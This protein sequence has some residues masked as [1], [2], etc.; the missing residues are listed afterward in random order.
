MTAGVTL[1]V[2]LVVLLVAT[3]LIALLDRL[4]IP[5]ARWFVRRRVN[6]AIDEM[7]TR[8]R[9]SVRPFQL[10]KRQV[11]LDRL[12][13]DAEVIQAMQA[14]AQEKGTPREV[15]ALLNALAEENWP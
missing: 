12:V 1:P 3:A 13:Y 5:S 9:I 8:L 10:T 11:L 15:A 7:N 6:R 14:Y 4:F 2:W